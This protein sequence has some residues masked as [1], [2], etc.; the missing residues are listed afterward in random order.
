MADAE[1]VRV[2]RLAKILDGYWVDPLLGLFL[3]GVGDLIGA[4]LGMYTV[5]VAV[6]R[7]MSPAIV[8]R[9]LLNLAVDAGVGALPLVGDAADFAIHANER[10]LRLLESRSATG[11]RSTWRDRAI[12]L[13]AIALFLAVIALVVYA[14]VRALQWI[15]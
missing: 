4:A 15:V 10:N 6:R 8:A 13:G 11:G 5:V 7:R 9:M 1:L 3:P 2:R 12:V 14:I